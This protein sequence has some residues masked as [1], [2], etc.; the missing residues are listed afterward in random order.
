MVLKF[1]LTKE[2]SCPKAAGCTWAP[3]FLPLEVFGG[4]EIGIRVVVHSA[5]HR[6]H[7]ISSIIFI[8]SIRGSALH[9][10]HSIS[11]IIFITSIRGGGSITR[12]PKH[13][14]ELNFLNFYQRRMTRPSSRDLSDFKFFLPLLSQNSS[15][16]EALQRFD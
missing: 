4:L 15:F 14:T 3:C 9:R 13:C 16:K 12:V 6:A 7:S 5:L 8:A 11:S 2:N 1:Q 10:V